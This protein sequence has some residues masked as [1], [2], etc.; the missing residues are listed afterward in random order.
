LP[1]RLPPSYGTIRHSSTAIVVKIVV[2][3]TAHL[4]PYWDQPALLQRLTGYPW[5]VTAV[6]HATLTEKGYKWS[7]RQVRYRL[8]SIEGGAPCPRI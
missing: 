2:K 8:G 5:W 3:R 4:R 6:T 1:H 7:I